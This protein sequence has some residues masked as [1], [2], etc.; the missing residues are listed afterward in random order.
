MRH[1][2]LNLHELCTPLGP[3]EPSEAL[4]RLRKGAPKCCSVGT[5]GS[6]CAEPLNRIAAVLTPGVRQWHA[7]DMPKGCSRTRNVPGTGA[8]EVPIEGE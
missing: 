7:R 2:I 5:L 1:V 6:S 8:A 4:A 3:L